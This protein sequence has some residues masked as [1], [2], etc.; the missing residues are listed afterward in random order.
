[1][2]PGPGGTPLSS[3]RLEALRDGIEDYEYLVLL[4]ERAKN[5]TEAAAQLKEASESLVTGA[6]SY[7]RDPLKLL[8]LRRRIALL[9]EKR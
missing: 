7:N 1:M 9:L 4:S 2:Y 3:L 5:N 6:T 8:D